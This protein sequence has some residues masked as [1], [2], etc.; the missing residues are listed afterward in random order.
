[1][2]RPLK[3]RP[4]LRLSGYNCSL[5]S[6]CNEVLPVVPAVI[7]SKSPTY[8]ADFLPGRADLPLAW[9]LIAR[10]TWI[11]SGAPVYRHLPINGQVNLKDAPGSE[12][13]GDFNVAFHQFNESFRNRQA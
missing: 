7:V 11:E 1:M 10:S 6:L 2:I 4:A 3:H 12:F 5:I 8:R 13:A 9:R